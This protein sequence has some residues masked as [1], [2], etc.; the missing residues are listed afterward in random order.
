MSLGIPYMGSK[1]KIAKPLIDYILNSNPNAKYFYDLFGGGG[2]MSF[3][4][5]KRKR[6]EKVSYNEFNEAIV[7]LL[8]KIKYD[9]VTPEFYE[10][11]DRETFNKYKDGNCWKSGLIKTCWSFGNNVDKG[12][13]FGANIEKYKMLL[14]KI[15]VNKCQLSINEFANLTSLHIDNHWLNNDDLHKR[16]LNIMRLIAKEK[17]RAD[18]ESL[19]NLQQLQN[20]QISSLSYEQVKIET[21]IS[22]TIIYCDPPYKGTAKY[23]KDINHDK[24]L[25]WVKNSPYK[26]YVSS[27]DFDLPCVFE[28]SHRSSLSATNNS[29]KVVEKLFCNQ[30]ELT[31]GTLF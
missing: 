28:L 9:G 26:I 15:I 11:I 16:R 2:A 13:L 18:L 10:W 7:N 22:E 5:L 21:P 1:R 24:F 12:Y 17:G 6:F 29:K 23:N 31:K 14:H 27:Y 20:L 25:E 30:E 8:I 19:Q 3:E 4:A